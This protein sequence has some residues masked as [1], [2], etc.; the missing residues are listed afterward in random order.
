MNSGGGRWE[1]DYALLSKDGGVVFIIEAKALGK[2]TDKARS[3]LLGYAMEASV[4]MGLTTDGK[5]WSFYLPLAAGSAEEKLVQSVDLMTASPEEAARVLVRYLERESVRSEQALRTATMDWERFA[6]QRTIQ[7]GWANLVA[8]PDD[9]LVKVIAGAA[10]MTAGQTGKKSVSVR[11]LSDAVRAFIRGGFA[12]LTDV[13]DVADDAPS[14]HSPAHAAVQPPARVPKAPG[15]G[16]SAAWTYGGERRVEK[17]AAA[18][19]VAVIGR[20]YEDYG[21]TDF[22]MRLRERLTGTRLIHIAPSP[23]EIGLQAS[24]LARVRPLPGG[25]HLNTNLSNPDKKRYLRR[26]CD[27]AGIAYGSDLVVEM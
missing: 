25:W 22:Y 10:K 23:S 7:S 24:L 15:A 11:V 13:P 14:R 6:L 21:G 16:G 1:L 9:K 8:G 20:L 3:Q 17:D 26:A 12:F 19:Y 4:Q 18:V 27:V 5:R 2:L